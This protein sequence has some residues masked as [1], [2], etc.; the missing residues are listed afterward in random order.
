MIFHHLDLPF[1]IHFANARQLLVL[2]RL[3]ELKHV[4][5]KPI[6]LHA[7]LTEELDE[8]GTV[9]WMCVHEV[10]EVD[11]G[12]LILFDV[13]LLKEQVLE[14]LKPLGK[15]IQELLLLFVSSHK[16][17][18]TDR[19]RQ[20]LALFAFG[21]TRFRRFRLCCLL[22]LIDDGLDGPGILPA[23]QLPVWPRRQRL[24]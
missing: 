3:C 19:D 13:A 20:Y 16:L 22:L 4:L 7:H 23:V 14:F 9:V 10:I 2:Q 1:H 8:V 5:S 24:Q 17:A 12:L 6:V 18:Y 15:Q 11:P 21:L